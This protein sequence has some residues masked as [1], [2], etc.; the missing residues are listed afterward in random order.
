M[1]Q[2]IGEGVI[3]VTADATGVRA[4]INDAKSALQGL[5]DAAKNAGET[6]DK[7]STNYLRSLEKQAASLERQ[8]ATFGKSK[9]EIAAYN[10]AQLGVSQTSAAMV[11]RLR[12]A[13]E[14]LNAQKAAAAAA[15]GGLVKLGAAQERVG[16]SAKATANALRGVPAQFTDIITSLQ[17]G[18]APFTVLLQQ[19]GQ[20]KDMFGG[21]GPAARALG[22]YVAGLINPF[23]LAAAAAV[24]LGAA[25]VVGSKES[26]A[27]QKAITLTGNYAGTTAGQL[28]DMA[29]TISATVG[30]QG[31]AAEVL[32]ELAA[33]GKI[34]GSSLQ[35]F[36]RAAI[37]M[38]RATGQAVAKTAEQFVSLADKPAEAAA[39]LN[40]SMH[41]LSAATYERI[42][43]L[44]EQGRKEEAAA[45]AQQTYANAIM[46]R[47][48]TV[49][50][51]LG[52]FERSWVSL[53]DAAK[54]AWDRIL[55]VGREDSIG[56]V[57]T[58][59]QK[60]L[61][62]L[63]AKQSGAGFFQRAP[64][65]SAVDAARNQVSAMIADGEMAIA[66][67]NAQADRVKNDQAKISAIQRLTEQ[68]KASRSR[69]DQR[70]EEIEQLDRDAKLVGM[71]ADDY[72]TRVSKIN[73]RYKDAKP[74]K[75]KEFRDDAATKMLQTLREQEASLQEQL[76]GV[77]KLTDA[78]KDRAKFLQLIS[79]L[80]E[81]KVL[82][83]DQKSLLNA[84][85]QIAAQLDLNVAA[86]R[87]VELAK[88]KEKQDVK[89]LKALADT[90]AKVEG[91]ARTIE[92][93]LEGQ[94]EQYDRTLS[95]FGMGSQ[96]LEQ[97]NSTKSILR[98]YRRYQAQLNDETSKQGTLGSDQYA[99]GVEQI[100]AGLAESLRLNTEY[101]DELRVKQGDWTNGASQ[102][103]ANYVDGARNAARQTE[104]L[105][106]RAFGGLED[107]LTSFVMTGKGDFKS[108]AN[109]IIA[110]LVRIQVKAALTGG[111]SAGGGIFG[112]LSGFF[113]SKGGAPGAPLS[114]LGEAGID[115]YLAAGGPAR[116]GG[117]YLVG[118]K[119]PEILRMGSQGGT[120][121]P[122]DKIGG[123]GDVYQN[124]YVI[125]DVASKKDVE[126]AVT[127]SQ[128]RMQGSVARSRAYGT[129]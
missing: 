3:K 109:S 26:S 100:R 32:A 84:K 105:F 49:A 73:E 70:K 5:K 98:E 8:A 93:S 29:R 79:D 28:S 42:A 115:N 122:N 108:L 102:A 117:T 44:E 33:T 37:E 125:G 69:A 99:K 4:G 126:D 48:K 74:A 96:A 45:L 2:T 36:A 128:R 43:S 57:I 71:A 65:K 25:F 58:K 40:E 39:K 63:E 107:A 76:Q 17:G 52:V 104:E 112:L 121:I 62:D 88:A 118:E 41:F 127:R 94:A 51:S 114:R 12:A 20:L 50:A 22:G 31:K 11:A 34:A 85:D 101:Y 56:D 75:P 59:A 106:T 61:A 27:Y 111:G 91:I 103:Y 6:L 55:N 21:I 90:Q 7:Q 116:A 124:T 47:T 72:N 110:D 19:G 60:Q 46:D 38:E 66:A 87:Q 95:V 24:S 83:T 77:T 64:G 120:V 97:L 35:S 113:G 86:S 119:G 15:A 13:E 23:A 53:G 81:K 18:Q 80:K 129:E 78:E 92:S 30:T 54:W 9:S 16:M 123:G 89:N 82:T 14:S 10:A 67:A 68:K 1:S